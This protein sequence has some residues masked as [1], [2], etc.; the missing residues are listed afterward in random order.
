MDHFIGETKALHAKPVA[1]V[2]V[3]YIVRPNFATSRYLCI[4][5]VKRCWNAAEWYSCTLATSFGF[6]P[7]RLWF[8]QSRAW[9]GRLAFYCFTVPP[10]DVLLFQIQMLNCSTMRCSTVP[11]WP[12]HCFTISVPMFHDQMIHCSTIRS[13]TVLPLDVE[14]YHHDCSTFPPS[15]VLLFHHNMFYCSTISVPL[16]HHQLFYC[17]TIR[18]STVPPSIV[19]LFH[20]DCSTVQQ[21]E[22]LLFHSSTIRC[23]TVPQSDVPLFYHQLF[24]SSTM[25]LPLFN[26]QRFYCS[27]LSPC[28]TV[29]LFHRE[30]VYCSTIIVSLLHHQML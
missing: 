5:I 13:S 30:V 15:D 1:W 11:P 26:N 12:F 14:L 29:P 6:S 21:S 2:S 17:S 20:H 24:P 10:L 18:C 27:T 28:S 4:E 19:P 23:S 9:L 7:T 22:I 25:I 8:Q 3:G 16:F